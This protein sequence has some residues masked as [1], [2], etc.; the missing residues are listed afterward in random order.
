MVDDKIKEISKLL[1]LVKEMDKPKNFTYMD[2]SNLY[3][4]LKDYK[5]LLV[6]KN[7]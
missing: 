3:E 1:Q 2:V 5:S 6:S 4:Y 7:S